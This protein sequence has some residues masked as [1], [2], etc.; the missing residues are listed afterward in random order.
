[1]RKERAQVLAGLLSS[2]G[3]ASVL[4]GKYRDR[5]NTL[6]Q[7]VSGEEGGEVERFGIF[8]VWFRLSRPPSPFSLS[9][10]NTGICSPCQSLGRSRRRLGLHSRHHA[11]VSGG[12]VQSEKAESAA[13]ARAKDQGTQGAGDAGECVVIVV[14]E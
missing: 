1:M 11:T 9:V 2:A 12:R 7:E 13:A 4:V 3:E 10:V 8:F 14:S 6:Q 5:M